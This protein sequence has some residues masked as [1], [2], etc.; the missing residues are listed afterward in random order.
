MSWITASMCCA[1][2][3]SAP[4]SCSAPTTCDHLLNPSLDLVAGGSYK[5]RPGWKAGLRTYIRLLLAFMATVLSSFM[6]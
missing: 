6:S 4:C 2:F 1:F 5:L 3:A